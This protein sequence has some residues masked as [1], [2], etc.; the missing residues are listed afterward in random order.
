LLLRFKEAIVRK[1]IVADPTTCYACLSCV[2]ECSARRAGTPNDA[3]LNA[4]SFC[5]AGCDVVG[6]GALA[7]PLFCNHCEDAP[8]ATVCPTGAMHRNEETGTVELDVERCIGCKACVVACPFGMVRMM[9]DGSAMIKCDLCADRQA[10]GLEPAC[11]AACPVGALTL[12]ELEDVAAEARRRAAVA[13]V[14]DQDAE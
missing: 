10:Q 6:V 14:A 7:V 11:V 4:A 8:C 2:V 5:Q 3:P 13:Q 9:P 1:V 12:K